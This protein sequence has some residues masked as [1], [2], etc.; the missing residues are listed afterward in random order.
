MKKRRTLMVIGLLAVSLLTGCSS[1]NGRLYRKS[2][3]LRMVNEDITDEQF[4]FDHIEKDKKSRPRV[5]TYYFSSKERDF[6]FT[7]VS[8]LRN[9][10]F[11]EPISFLYEKV[12]KIKYVDEVQA[13]Y[14][15]EVE[16]IVDEIPYEMV[17]KYKAYRYTSYDDLENV[18]KILTRADDV[19]KAE[20]EYNSQEWLKK[21][22]IWRDALYYK[23][24]DENGETY[25]NVQ[26]TIALDGSRD[27]AEM[28]DYLTYMHIQKAY[29]GELTDGSIPE[30]EMSRA[31]KRHLVPYL[32]GINVKEAACEQDKAAGLYNRSRAEDEQTKY[33]CSYYYNWDS[34]IMMI[35]LGLTN[36]EYAPKIVEYYTDN[37]LYDAKVGNDNGKVSWDNGVDK[38][39]INATQ[40]DNDITS[41]VFTRN[42][43]TVDIPYI[44]NDDASIVGATYIVGIHLDDF[45]DMF[46]LK[47]ILN[48]DEGTVVFEGK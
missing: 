47:Y 21:Y 44:T 17:G 37:L 25:S 8:T 42:G 18:A 15:N 4:V 19:Y 45:A 1:K 7:A 27:Y 3:V 2:E 12:L 29:D 38:W 28:Y 33:S 40:S 24:L 34:Y 22:P 16:N 9:A 48:E 20:L 6:T 10:T 26:F 41:C 23:G 43:T 11:V 30:S 39:T 5:D 13:L 14:K 32:N 35:N 31:H 46:N 36:P